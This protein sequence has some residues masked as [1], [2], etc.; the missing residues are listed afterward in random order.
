MDIPSKRPLWNERRII[1]GPYLPWSLGLVTIL[2]ISSSLASL[3]AHHIPISFVPCEY[4]KRFHA[5]LSPRMIRI[6]SSSALRFDD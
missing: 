1:F 2:R 4:M 5:D 3:F 6:F